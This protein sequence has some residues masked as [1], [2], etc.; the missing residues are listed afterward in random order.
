MSRVLEHVERVNAEAVIIVP[1]DS[2]ASSG[3]A[4]SLERG[5][6]VNVAPVYCLRYYWRQVDGLAR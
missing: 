6:S 3:A 1:N 4:T 2:G 5:D